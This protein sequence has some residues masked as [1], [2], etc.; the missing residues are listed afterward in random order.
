MIVVEAK[1]HILKL[2]PYLGCALIT[3]HFGEAWRM[4]AAYEVDLR[5]I[6]FIEMLPKA[7]SKI[8]PSFHP[9][10]LLIGG[11]FALLLRLI[12]YVKS[13]DAK[14]YRKGVEYGSA[15]WGAYYQL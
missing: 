8:L 3:T 2:L 7:F 15:R 9:F 12:A 13:L 5:I 4:S 14:T 11:A 6:G 1:R 10:D